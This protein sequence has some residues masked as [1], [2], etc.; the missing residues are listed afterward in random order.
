MR[1]GRTLYLYPRSVSAAGAVID[2]AYNYFAN[3]TAN[4][5]GCSH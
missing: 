3:S 5:S 1:G 4:G 2:R